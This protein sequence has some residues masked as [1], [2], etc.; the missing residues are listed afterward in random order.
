MLF[1]L[2]FT[3]L[4][5]FPQSRTHYYIITDREGEL[6]RSSSLVLCRRRAGGEV[7][8]LLSNC[9]ELNGNFVLLT[10]TV[11]RTQF[12]ALYVLPGNVSRNSI[13]TRSM[14]NATYILVRTASG[15]PTPIS[16]LSCTQPFRQQSNSGQYFSRVGSN[17]LWEK[18]WQDER[19]REE[20]GQGAREY[21]EISPHCF[22]PFSQSRRRFPLMEIC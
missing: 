6:L 15:N 9:S 11:V 14:Y 17:M 5:Y 21:L 8:R 22:S 12:P 10:Y 3:S 1:L 13:L 19:G 18:T 4:A 20:R 16:P 2:H 7:Y